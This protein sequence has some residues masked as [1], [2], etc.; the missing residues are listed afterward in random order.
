MSNKSKTKPASR[1]RK[2][3]DSLVEVNTL[4][5]TLHLPS[6]EHIDAKR[7][8]VMEGQEDDEIVTII[9]PGIKEFRDITDRGADC[10]GIWPGGRIG[11]VVGDELHFNMY[12]YVYILPLNP[13]KRLERKICRLSHQAK[14]YNGPRDLTYYYNGI[15]SAEVLMIG[16]E[17]DLETYKNKYKDKMWMPSHKEY[18]ETIKQYCP[19]MTPTIFM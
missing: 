17:L 3:T 1:K 7:R 6:R 16:E 18:C 14:G 9:M 5:E 4:N 10:F 19:R 8:K 11:Y 12:N 15:S 13:E 2:R